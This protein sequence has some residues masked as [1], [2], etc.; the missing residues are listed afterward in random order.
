MQCAICKIEMKKVNFATGV[1]SSSPYLW[2][3]KKGILELEKTSSISC[4]VCIE[5]GKIEFIAD[6]PQVFKNI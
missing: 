2:Y 1:T 4:Y 6:K 5:C 3:K